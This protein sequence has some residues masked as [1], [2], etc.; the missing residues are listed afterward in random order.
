[1]VTFLAV[2]IQLPLI[3]DV[4]GFAMPKFSVRQFVIY[5]P[6]VVVVMICGFRYS[7]HVYLHDAT[8]RIITEQRKSGAA[9]LGNVEGAVGTTRTKHALIDLSRHD[10]DVLFDGEARCAQ[11]IRPKSVMGRRH[12]IAMYTLGPDRTTRY[13]YFPPGTAI[14]DGEFDRDTLLVRWAGILKLDDVDIEIPRAEPQEISIPW[15]RTDPPQ[16]VDVFE[17]MML[18]LNG[19]ESLDHG[20]DHQAVNRSRQ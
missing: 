11:L 13:V 18:G 9:H 2:A 3:A 5:L 14:V 8:S 20:S 15:Q 12:G 1:M 17:Q 4:I 19:G 6:I 7:R 10:A 16:F